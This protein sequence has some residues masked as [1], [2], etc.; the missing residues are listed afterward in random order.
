MLNKGAHEG[1]D[2]AV[3]SGRCQNQLAIT[4]RIL[5]CFGHIAAG[6][7]VDSHLGAAVL[8][9]QLG[10]LFHRLTGVAI[11]GGVGDHNAVRLHRIAGPGII[12][13]DIIRQILAQHRAVQ[14]ADRPDIQRGSF[15]EKRLSRH[16]VFADDPE[17]VP[18]RLAG[19]VLLDV[20]CTELAERIGREQDLILA[21][22][23]HDHFRPV[24]HG[25]RPER[26]GTA[27]QRQGVIIPHGDFFRR[28]IRA[29]EVFHH[30]KSLCGGH[31]G[32]LRERLHET[33]NAAGMVRLHMLDDQIVRLP[34]AQDGADVAKPDI[35]IAGV[36][37]I[38]NGDLLVQD[39][40]GIICH[41]VRHHIL[42]FK[43]I[44]V[45]VV[46]TCIL[47]GIGNCHTAAFFLFIAGIVLLPVFQF[48][49][50]AS[51]ALYIK[52]K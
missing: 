37:G 27:A 17:I 26:E 9:Q 36:H 2:I 46:D 38:H 39:H 8:L 24:H 52:G 45:M 47:N 29:E 41:A 13:A 35:R 6:Q 40:I 43:K 32:R 3:V 21:V 50:I 5:H 19:P 14:R 51:G 44:K 23:G 12:K 49:I 28:R 20:Q 22:V 30:G 1:E 10:Q 31:N 11:H 42:P 15:F 7:I 4:E 25:R 18:P 33:E 34:C 16:A 48:S